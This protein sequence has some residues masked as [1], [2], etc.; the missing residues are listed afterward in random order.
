[1]GDWASE[2]RSGV[3][4]MAFVAGWRFESPGLLTGVSFDLVLLLE[5]SENVLQTEPDSVTDLEVREIAFSHPRFNC[6]WSSAE[7][8]GHLRLGEQA[9]WRTNIAIILVHDDQASS[10]NGGPGGGYFAFFGHRS[11][12]RELRSVEVSPTFYPAIET[13]LIYEVLWSR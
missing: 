7:K 3:A 10:I 9:F 13:T 5:L 4:E 11:R 2:S 8:A 12:P 6:A 1:M